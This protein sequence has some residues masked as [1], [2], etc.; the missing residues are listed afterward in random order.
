[1]SGSGRIAGALV[2]LA[3]SAACRARPHVS[4]TGYVGTWQRGDDRARSTISIVKQ[5]RGYLFRWSES[6]EGNVR[7]V[8]CGWNGECDEIIDGRSVAHYT[9]RTRIDEATGHLEVECSGR[10]IKPREMA[11]H[12][13]DRLEVES[14]GTYLAFHTLLRNG[15]RFPANAGPT[16]WFKKVSDEVYDPP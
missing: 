13:V 12:D 15:Q 5:G 1:M 8:R 10:V 11:V 14:G 2:V 16:R 9:F 3:A 6:S 4:D 7:S